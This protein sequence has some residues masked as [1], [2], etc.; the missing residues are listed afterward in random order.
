MNQN[1]LERLFRQWSDGKH[2]FSK[3]YDT[4]NRF[5]ILCKDVIAGNK[6][7]SQTA[8]H[9]GFG[10]PKDG[11]MPLR[12]PAVL[13][14]TL[15]SMRWL[16]QAGITPPQFSI[17]QVTSVISSI[18]SID[19][20]TASLNAQ[21]MESRLYDFVKNNFSELLEYITFTFWEKE[22]DMEVVKSICKYVNITLEVLNSEEKAYFQSCWEKHSNGKVN[23]L[24]YT[25]ANTFYN[26]WYPE[27]PFPEMWD[28]T[29]IIPV[30]WRSETKFFEALLKTQTSTREILPL[31]TQVWAFPTYYRAPSWDVQTYEEISEY[32]FG[33]LTVHPDIEKDIKILSQYKLI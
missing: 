21:M 9:T 1:N 17:Y 20:D 13:V 11:N 8:F 3:T 16:L 4:S 22:S 23:A 10:I 32:V 6:D 12:L 18:N 26:W 33:H 25:T 5:S 19:S 28:M 31:I 14:P 15:E 7:F 27:S 29:E 2:K 24:Y 30:G